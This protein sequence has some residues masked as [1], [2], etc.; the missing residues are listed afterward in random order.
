MQQVKF[1][2]MVNIGYLQNILLLI[3]V[4]SDY[5]VLVMHINLQTAND[6]F[7]QNNVS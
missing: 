6:V 3:N 2:L 1:L 5:I 4:L 7:R